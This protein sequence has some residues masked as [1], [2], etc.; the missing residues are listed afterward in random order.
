MLLDLRLF[1]VAQIATK[2][3]PEAI[4]RMEQSMKLLEPYRRYKAVALSL[5]GLEIQHQELKLQLTKCKKIV[6]ERGQLA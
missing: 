3:L 2:D 4:K 5:Q 1:K 6:E